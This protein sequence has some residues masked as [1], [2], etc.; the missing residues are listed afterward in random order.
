M[1]YRH[2]SASVSWRPI[3]TNFTT[4]VHIVTDQCTSLGPCL[5]VRDAVRQQVT[6]LGGLTEAKPIV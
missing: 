1:R 5:S 6:L 4:Q 2:V 3:V